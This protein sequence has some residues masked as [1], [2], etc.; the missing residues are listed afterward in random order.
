MKPYTIHWLV[1]L[2]MFPLLTIAQI[3]VSFP[4]S[5]AVFQRSTNNEAKIHINGYYTQ[6]VTRIEARVQAR[7]G[8]G[9][10]SDWVT[11]QPSPAVVLS[12]HDAR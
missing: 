6:P 12:A 3:Q 1:G 5:R 9:I 8:Q 2:L 10:S 11:I 7:N 4:V